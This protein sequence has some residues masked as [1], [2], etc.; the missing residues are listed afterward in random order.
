LASF[1][2]PDVPKLIMPPVVCPPDWAPAFKPTVS[3]PYQPDIVEDKP[4]P[5]VPV[6][7]GVPDESTAAAKSNVPA[8]EEFEVYVPPFKV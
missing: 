6:V 2:P 8:V 5:P 4:K 7:D 1:V 3:P